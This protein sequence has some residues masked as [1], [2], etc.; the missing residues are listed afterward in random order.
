MQIADTVLLRLLALATAVGLVAIGVAGGGYDVVDRQTAGLL[1]WWAVGLAALVLPRLPGRPAA[2]GIAVTA[3]ATLIP[4]WIAFGLSDSLSTERTAVELARWVAYLA[5]VVLVGWVLPRRAWPA[6]AGGLIAGAVIVCGIAFEHRLATGADQAVVFLSTTARL[7]EP[8][9]YWNAVGSWAVVTSLLLLATSS[10]APQWWVRAPALGALPM[11]TAVAYLTYSRSA[12]GAAAL[13]LVVAYAFARHRWTFALHVL[14]AVGATVLTVTV[15]GANPEIADAT[16]TGGAGS[17]LG[18]VIGSGLAL[19]IAAVATGRLGL[20]EVALPPRIGRGVAA[21]TVGVALAG[22]VAGAAIY[23][24]EA[25]SKFSTVEQFDASA[26]AERLGSLNNGARVEQWRIAL[27]QWEDERARGTGA[28]TFELTYNVRGKDGQFVRDAHSAYLEALSEQGT[29]GLLLLVGFTLSAAWA[30]LIAL[31]RTWDSALERGLVAGVAAGLAAFIFGTGFDWFWEVGALALLGMGLLGVLIAAGSAP[32][33]ADRAP[34]PAWPWRLAFAGTALLG[35]L[36]M[37]PGLVG[38]SDIRRSQQA[39]ASGDVGQARS[40]A[41][42]AIDTMPWA[43]SPF[44]QRALVDE[45]AGEYDAARDGIKLAI[46][47][48]PHDWRLPLVLARIEARDGRP[49]QALAAYRQGKQLR[50]KGQFFR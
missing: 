36:I 19:A 22:G 44:L 18:V 24:G 38:T 6:V 10:H 17:V 32:P 25:W 46:E 20:D 47:R 15:I 2:A 48:D 49:K 16:G 4:V 21:I 7:A 43:S 28:G 3:F 8:F 13:G 9:G 1:L 29:I 23:G 34:G 33:V 50:P 37:L 5:P 41:D 27:Q 12:L 42:Q 35:V 40:Y 30:A 14:L 26:Q 39:L 31:R 45:Q 11:V